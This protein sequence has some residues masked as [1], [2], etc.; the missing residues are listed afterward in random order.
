MLAIDLISVVPQMFCGFFSSSILA[1]A[2]AQNKVSIRT[3]DLR[4][5]ALDRRRTVDERPYSGGPGMLMQCPV[6]IEAIENCRKFPITEIE[7][8]THVIL[9]TPTGTLFTQ[10]MA[11]DFAQAGHLIFLCGHYEGI[12]ARVRR[13]VTDEVSLGDFVLTGGEIPVAAMVDAT[14]RLLPGVLGAGACGT[15]QESFGAEGLLEAPQW[16]R[17]ATYRGL[18]VPPLLEEGNHARIEQW[19]KRQALDLTARQ[20]PDLLAR[21]GTFTPLMNP[22][23]LHPTPENKRSDES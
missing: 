21:G 5:F 17:P 20:R 3:V 2:Q 6:W 15:A 16:T 8:A 23:V 12:D 18:S 14:V 10:R 1:R 11:E 7:G 22:D 9:T 19:R 13:Y 4:D